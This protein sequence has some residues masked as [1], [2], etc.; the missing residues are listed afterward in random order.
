MYEASDEPPP[1][2]PPPEPTAGDEA[3][4]RRVVRG[5]VAEPFLY[6]V[7]N[8]EGAPPS[9]LFGLLPTGVSFD[10]AFPAERL[11]LID[12]ARVLYVAV[13]PT[14][15]DPAEVSRVLS[16]RR[17]TAAELFPARVWHALTEE[18]RLTTPVEQLRGARPF[19]SQHALL[20]AR[21]ATLEPDPPE[22]MLDTFVRYV[23]E[24]GKE[25]QSFDTLVGELRVLGTIPDAQFVALTTRMV[26][27]REGT[28]QRL[29]SMRESY[30]EGDEIRIG[31]LLDDPEDRRLAPALSR[32]MSRR[33][34]EWLAVMRREIDEGTAFFA[35]EVSH[36]LGSEGLIA[37]LREAGYTVERLD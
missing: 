19:Y 35:L 12:Q 31:Q 16:L 2:P 15:P 34:D 27:D 1:P 33:H 5:A 28:D 24:R 20:N 14:T 32:T 18:L 13:D 4:T 6:V 22:P 25:L 37:K 30:L 11:D 7:R 10:Q 8:A 9:L 26:D 17:G 21:R 36:L 23:G 29:L 3:P